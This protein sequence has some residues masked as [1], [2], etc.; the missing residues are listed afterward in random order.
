MN[1]A[2]RT[3]IDGPNVCLSQD[4]CK[5]ECEGFAG[6]AERQCRNCMCLMPNRVVVPAL[7]FDIFKH[8][9]ITVKDITR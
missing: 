1:I 4:S 9:I 6:F 5:D 8:K 7:D 3:S 2:V